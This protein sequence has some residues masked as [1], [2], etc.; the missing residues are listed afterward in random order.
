MLTVTSLPEWLYPGPPGGWT[1]DDLDA[2]PPGAPRRVE[3]IDGALILMSPQTLFHQRMINQLLTAI[4]PPEGWEVVR[5]MSIRLSPR[6][7]PEPDLM[8]VTASSAADQDRTYFTPGDVRLIVEVVSPDSEER[9]RI[10][11][12]VKYAEAGIRH[13]WIVER[14]GDAPVAYTY[15]LDTSTLG[16]YIPTGVHRGR[17]STDIGF[18]VGIDLTIRA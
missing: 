1:A 17:L 13:Y 16:G 18:P 10:T 2:L 5:E 8:V 11:K 15:E 9:D 3:L 12:R 7:R 6:Q 14:D 4:R